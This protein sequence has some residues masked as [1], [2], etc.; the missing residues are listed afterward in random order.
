MTSLYDKLQGDKLILVASLPENKY[1]LAKAA[2]DN[3]ADAVK[4][5]I[6]VSHRASGTLFR[7]FHEEQEQIQRILNDSPV[8]VGLVAGGSTEEVL[9]DYNTIT[10][11]PFDFL[12]LYLHA[13]PPEILADKKLTCMMACDY[14]YLPSEIKQFKHL[15]VDILEASVIHPDLY[16]TYLNSRDL[17]RYKELVAISNLPV[18]VPSQ[19]KIRVEDVKCLAETGVKGIMLGAVVTG[20]SEDSIKISF[21]QFRAAIDRL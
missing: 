4:I 2:W 15:N 9:G 12:S 3:G 8:P 18:I 20:K 17:L 16:G 19:K 10:K 1:E 6:N 7:S 11:H 14:T 21:A 5:H 13:A